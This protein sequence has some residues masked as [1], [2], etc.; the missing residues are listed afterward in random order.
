MALEG[1]AEGVYNVGTGRPVRILD[2]AEMLIDIFDSKV[3]PK[4]T[5]EFR[6]GDNRHDFADISK[7]KKELNFQPKWDLKQ[8]LEKFV[9][10]AESQEAIDMFER[11]EKERKGYLGK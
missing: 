1:S 11:A 8:G 4:I 7:I 5:E 10:W 6:I 3:K 2:I 9:E